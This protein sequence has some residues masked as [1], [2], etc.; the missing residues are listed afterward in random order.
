MSSNQ[1]PGCDPTLRAAELDERVGGL[2]LPHRY[3]SLAIGITGAVLGASAVALES[4]WLGA[5]AGLAA[6]V[7]GIL[8][9]IRPPV[10]PTTSPSPPVAD[11][12]S[13]LG[14]G[15]VVAI[16]VDLDPA[17]RRIT[18]LEAEVTALSDAATLPNPRDDRTAP[19]LT[20]GP[21]GLFTET[22]FHVALESRL[23]AARR[24]LR[25]VAV[26]LMR[27]VEGPPGDTVVAPPPNRLAE[28]IRETIR[29]A[30]I[31]C[32]LDDGTFAVVLEDTP[33]NGA[34]WTTERIRR[35][36]VSRH[37]THTL[38]A[39]IACYPAHAFASDDLYRQATQ[40]LTAAQ[41]WRQDRIEVAL[42]D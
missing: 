37:G 38:W 31:A 33:E 32:R 19:T 39:G 11:D 12:A 6:L 14:L 2:T 23:A 34:V 24:H 35:N 18:D 17:H 25:P 15:A 20:D 10:A 5:A 4:V 42:S 28:A 40:A 16:P 36:L 22:Y 30:D 13:D 29:E 21:S 26:T 7:L 9:V 27:S 1:Q 8:A 3:I 41:D